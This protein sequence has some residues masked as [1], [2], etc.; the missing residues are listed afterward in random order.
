[1]SSFC[2]CKCK[3]YIFSAKIL[4]NMPYLLI[5]V[6]MKR[7]LMT[8]LVLNNWAQVYI[9]LISPWKSLLRTAI[10]SA[11]EEVLLINTTTHDSWKNKKKINIFAWKSI[12][13][14]RW[15]DIEQIFFLF[16]C[17]MLWVLIRSAWQG[18]FNAYPQHIFLWRKTNNIN[19]F[20]LK[21]ASL[22]A[23]IST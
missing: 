3:S 14:S 8:S 23:G 2:K 9:F 1:M 6:L 12:L 18:T 20:W 22:S 11:N 10:R 7:Y 21:N 13:S 15:R 16:L 17:E 5:K 19:I 4:A